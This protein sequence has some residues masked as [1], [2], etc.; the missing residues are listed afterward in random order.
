MVNPQAKEAA[1][2]KIQVHIM[3]MIW[4][5]D[6]RDITHSESVP[7]RITV[8]TFYVDVSKRLIDA[9]RRKRGELF[10]STTTRRKFLR[11]ECRSC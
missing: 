9:V 11:F 5:F 6:F 1:I 4:F 3:L 2:V 7:E 8:K 10:F